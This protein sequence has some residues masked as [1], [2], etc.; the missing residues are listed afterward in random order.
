MGCADITSWSLKIMQLGERGWVQFWLYIFMLGWNGEKSEYYDTR[1][2]IQSED[3]DFGPLLYS[4]Q[5]SWLGSCLLHLWSSFWSPK[6]M[7]TM[8]LSSPNNIRGDSRIVKTGQIGCRVNREH[9]KQKDW[10]GQSQW[11]TVPTCKMQR[12]S[13]VEFDRPDRRH[14]DLSRPDQ[15]RRGVLYKRLCNK[16]LQS[17]GSISFYD[18]FFIGLF[19][20]FW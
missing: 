6:K 5:T 10:A 9:S 19:A 2:R 12:V 4:L 1:P 8:T 14:W 18:P 11:D 15:G 17:H 7:G 20:R 16:E 3:M 13:V